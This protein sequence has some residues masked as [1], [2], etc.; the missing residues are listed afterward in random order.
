MDMGDGFAK[1]RSSYDELELSALIDRQDQLQRR[2][3][4][5]V[6]LVGDTARRPWLL[7]LIFEDRLAL[8]VDRLQGGGVQVDATGKGVPRFNHILHT[9]R[10]ATSVSRSQSP[11]DASAR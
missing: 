5:L 4:V 11:E 1:V 7:R 8:L 3:L 2:Y 6:A 10:V 9:C